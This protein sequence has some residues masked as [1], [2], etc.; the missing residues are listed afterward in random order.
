MAGT[1]SDNG[2]IWVAGETYGKDEQG[3]SVTISGSLP[4]PEIDDIT[5]AAGVP[6]DSPAYNKGPFYMDSNNHK[7]YAWNVDHWV[8]ASG[9]NT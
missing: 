1:I 9:F 8:P 2:V 7:I 3:A 4:H 6:T 5:F